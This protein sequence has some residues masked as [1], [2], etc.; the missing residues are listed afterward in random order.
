MAA[1]DMAA[2]DTE[3]EEEDMG[4]VMEVEAVMAGAE[5]EETK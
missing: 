1:E 5:V 3:G 2:E 4:V